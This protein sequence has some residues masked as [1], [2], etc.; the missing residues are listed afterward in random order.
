MI[1]LNK[2][3]NDERAQAL[4][5]ELGFLGICDLVQL[6]AERMDGSIECVGPRIV[7]KIKKRP[8]PKRVTAKEQKP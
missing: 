1:F 8:R 4:V 5:E 3:L 6:M 7:V 2:A